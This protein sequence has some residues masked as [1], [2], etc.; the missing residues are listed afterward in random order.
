MGANNGRPEYLYLSTN[1]VDAQFYGYANDEY[2]YVVLA[3]TDVP[4]AALGV[5]SEDSQR[6]TV[7]EEV[8]DGANF[9]GR[10]VLTRP[11]P[12]RHFSRRDDST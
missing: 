1:P 9:P 7:E 2:D 4:L 5:D 3:V 6:S 8:A 12:A 10:L 11:I